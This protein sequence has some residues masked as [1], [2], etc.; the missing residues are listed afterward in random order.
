MGCDFESVYGAN[1]STLSPIDIGGQLCWERRI[2]LQ[3]IPDKM[4]GYRSMTAGDYTRD[5]ERRTTDW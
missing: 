4:M 2:S 5:R 1:H 3:N